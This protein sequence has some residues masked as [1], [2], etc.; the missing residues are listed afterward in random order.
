MLSWK[1]GIIII[2][3]ILMVIGGSSGSTVGGIKIIRFITILKAIEKNVIEIVSPEGRI[4]KTKIKNK[5]I[6]DKAIKESCIYFLIFILLIIV[7]WIVLLSQGYDSCYSLFDII[8]AVSNN[9]LSL[10]MVNLSMP[11]VVKLTMIMD[12]LLGKLE[13]IPIIVLI[14]AFFEFGKLNKSQKNKLKR[15]KAKF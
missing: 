1:P 13:I 8:S 3:M 15:I 10:G 4:I 9:G 2:L 7:S 11:V 14:R 6:S 12:M 5:N